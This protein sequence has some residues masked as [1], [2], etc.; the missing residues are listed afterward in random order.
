MLRVLIN[1]LFNWR[2]L[3]SLSLAVRGGVDESL[4][5]RDE[6]EREISPMRAS[7]L[8]LTICISAIS[9]AAKPVLTDRDQI[10]A[11]EEAWGRALETQDR[12]ALERIVASDF[13]FIEPDG[14][15]LT[16]AAYLADRANNPAEI[17]SFELSEMFVR[18]I[19]ETALVSGLSTID[20]SIAAKRYKYQL[21]WK[22]MWVKRRGSWQVLAGQATPVNA[23]WNVPFLQGAL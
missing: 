8:I 9:S 14:S 21:R 11:L 5:C 17:H 2:D 15:V 4:V 23:A 19:D 1:T 13:T 20:E 10:L 18:I 7:F 12:A 22:E 6:L 16:R 3:F